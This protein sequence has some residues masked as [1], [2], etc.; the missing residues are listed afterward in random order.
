MSVPPITLPSW[1]NVRGHAHVVELRLTTRFRGITIREAVVFPLQHGWVEF[2]PFADYDDSVAASWLAAAFDAGMNGMPAACRDAVPVNAT[3]PAVKPHEVSAAVQKFPGAQVA[4]I[5]VAERGQSLTDDLDRVHAVLSELGASGRVRLDANGGW[6]VATAIKAVDALRGLPVE[7]VEQ[8]CRTVSELAEVRRH[9]LA[10][11]NEIRIAADE[12]I[13]LAS[14]PYRV[15]EAQAAD[16]AVVK[17]PPLAGPRRALALAGDLKQRYN[18]DVVYS[19]ALDTAIG[20]TIGVAVAAAATDL[21]FACGLATSR[22]FLDDIAPAPAYRNGMLQAPTGLAVPDPQALVEYQ[23][24]P[25]RCVWWLE[26]LE[27][28]YRIL[29]EN[30][31]NP[32]VVSDGVDGGVS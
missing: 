4:K 20:M 24:G 5:K 17:V 16:I 30:H 3:I 29:Q 13:R 11:G 15:A 32:P 7:Y 1:D 23:A 28:C 26:R 12:S 31:G 22:L 6:D 25:E 9:T 18:M 21:P 14:D 8:P 2:A 10:T 27:R 19:S